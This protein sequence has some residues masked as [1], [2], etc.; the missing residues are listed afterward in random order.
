MRMRVKVLLRQVS[1]KSGA[2]VEHSSHGSHLVTGG[3]QDAFALFKGDFPGSPSQDR[4]GRLRGV[5]YFDHNATSPL[6]GVARDAWLAACERYPGNA[7][8]PHRLGS[9]AEAALESAR[10]SAAEFLKCSPL[11]IVWTSGATEANNALF[12]NSSLDAPNQVWVS[13]I[14]HPSIMEAAQKYFPGAV[15]LIPVTPQGVVEVDWIADNLKRGRPAL[16]AVMAAN[17]ETGV[18][19]PWKDVLALCRER[20]I[21]F[22]CDAAQWIGKLPAA[23]LGECD[24]VSGCAHKFGGP[25]GVGFMK[26]P[27]KFRGLIVGGGQEDGRRAGTQNV[28]GA[29]AMMAAWQLRERQISAGETRTRE[30]WRNNFA[31]ELQNEIEDFEVVGSGTARL[32]NT[33]AALMPPLEDCRRRWVVRMDKSGFAVSTGSACASGKEKPSHVVS[34]MGFDTRRSDRMLRFSA[35]WETTESDWAA[36]KHAVQECCQLEST[37]GPVK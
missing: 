32:W 9:R 30:Q 20:E 33:V 37:S 26:V 12:H 8:S 31:A 25:V 16:A 17:N 4:F 18:L 34:A 22:A 13:A 5:I 15:R 27:S 29:L 10:Q 28:A 7:A 23:G 3:Y 36:L 1:D 11:D 24:F 14:E 19:Q 21:P 6:C 35:G 2:L